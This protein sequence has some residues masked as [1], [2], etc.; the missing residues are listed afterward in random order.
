MGALDYLCGLI[1]TDGSYD[2]RGRGYTI[3][4]AEREW[5]LLYRLADEFGG[6]VW[7]K[8]RVRILYV[9]GLPPGLDA[10]FCS[11]FKRSRAG[12]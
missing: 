5:P 10:D 3:A 2:V 4:Q 9:E 12:V 7:G 1:A 6:R 8:R 11:Q